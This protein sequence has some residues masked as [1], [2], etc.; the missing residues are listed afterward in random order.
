M[1][2]QSQ[3][4][5]TEVSS[6]CSPRLETEAANRLLTQQHQISP[7]Q[8]TQADAYHQELASITTWVKEEKMARA[9]MRYFEAMVLPAVPR[10][11][12]CISIPMDLWRGGKRKKKKKSRLF[13]VSQFI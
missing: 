4:D 8:C 10:A 2:L 5:P 9:T 3:F 1:W 7:S 11:P 6:P 12:L 13:I